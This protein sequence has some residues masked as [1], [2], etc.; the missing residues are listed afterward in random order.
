VDINEPKV[1][2]KK[3]HQPTTSEKREKQI[4]FHLHLRELRRDPHI[5]CMAAVTRNLAASKHES[6]FRSEYCSPQQPCA[7]AIAQAG[8]P[9]TQT[10][11]SAPRFYNDQCCFPQLTGFR[12]RRCACQTTK[13]VMREVRDSRDSAMQQTVEHLQ[14]DLR[15]PMMTSLRSGR[16]E[17][18]TAT[19]PRT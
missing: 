6:A 16:T 8:V 5:A 4:Y 1:E 19:G 9:S 18:A 10:P 2:K 17:A 7:R 13:M 11:S 3:Y 12:M 15:R 14:P